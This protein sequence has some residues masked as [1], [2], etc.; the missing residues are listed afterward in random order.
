MAKCNTSKVICPG[1]GEEIKIDDKKF[2]AALDKPYTNTVW[3]RYCWEKHI[4]E[5]RKESINE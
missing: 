3:H 4:A 5:C 2:L 1:C